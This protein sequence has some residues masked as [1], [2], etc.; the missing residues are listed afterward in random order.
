MTLGDVVEGII[1][2][3]FCE[4][5]SKVSSLVFHLIIYIACFSRY[6]SY[7]IHDSTGRDPDEDWLHSN[8]GRGCMYMMS[9]PT[10]PLINSLKTYNIKM[11]EVLKIMGKCYR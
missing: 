10:H 4:N 7:L 9:M 8:V 6:I 11:P 2:E 5:D 1:G 3:I